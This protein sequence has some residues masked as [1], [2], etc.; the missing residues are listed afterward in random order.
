[1]AGQEFSQNLD[2][3]DHIAYGMAYGKAHV[4]MMEGHATVELTQQELANGG[5]LAVQEAFDR[6]KG[7]VILGTNYEVSTMPSILVLVEEDV[8][9]EEGV[10]VE[11]SGPY[12]TRE[13][14]VEVSLIEESK[15]YRRLAIMTAAMILTALAVDTAKDSD[16]GFDLVPTKTANTSDWLQE[17]IVFQTDAACDESSQAL[18]TDVRISHPGKYD[19]QSDTE[20]VVVHGAGAV[21]DIKET[22][23]VEEVFVCG[24]NAVLRIH[25]NATVG[26]G[27]VLGAGAYIDVAGQAESLYMAGAGTDG[28]VSGSVDMFIVEGSGTNVDVYG[29]LSEGIAKGHYPY[30]VFIEVDGGEVHKRTVTD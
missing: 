1:M 28:V 13:E 24:A 12:S 2:E 16:D 11:P 26:K 7:S 14:T 15:R 17:D 4:A 30:D 25:P 22:A 21:V 19:I 3:V 29:D 23:D 10:L 27:G 8:E 9:E 6:L 18:P 20:R 5:E